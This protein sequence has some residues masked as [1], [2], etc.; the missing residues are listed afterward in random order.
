MFLN[1][2]KSMERQE[3]KN[4]CSK[5]TKLEFPLLYMNTLG[6]VSSSL[7]LEDFG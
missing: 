6:S 3:K 7:L 1:K 4:E 5:I 2:D